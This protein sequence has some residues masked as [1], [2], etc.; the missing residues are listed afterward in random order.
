MTRY[1]YTRNTFR[2]H[3][4]DRCTIKSRFVPKTVPGGSVEF[5]RGQG[6]HL[7]VTFRVSIGEDFIEVFQH[8]GRADPAFFLRAVTIDAF[9]FAGDQA[10]LH[11]PPLRIPFPAIERFAVEEE[12]GGGEG[13]T[14]E[15]NEGE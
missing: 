5:L 8:V 12:N 15:R 10:I 6:E 1:C 11:T 3:K 4:T 7:T 9:D 14:G 13:G 2:R